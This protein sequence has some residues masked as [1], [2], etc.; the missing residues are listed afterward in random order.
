[1]KRI[2]L[3]IT[4]LFA[5]FIFAYAENNEV[6][7]IGT[8]NLRM[9]TPSDGDDSWSH[10]KEMVKDLLRFVDYDLL[11]TQEGFSHQLNDILQ[12]GIYKYIGA[13]RDDGKDAGEHSAIFYRADRFNVLEQGNFWLSETPDKPGLGWDATC[14]NRICSWGKFEDVKSGRQF[15]F[16]NVHFD[17]EGVVARRESSHLMMKRIKSIAGDMPVFLTGDF[18]AFPTDEP[19]QILDKSGFLKDA[20]KI[21]KELPFGPVCTYH[22]YDS[23]VKTDERI[24]YVWVTGNIAID[25]YGVLTNTLYGR[26]PSDHFP[27]LVVAEF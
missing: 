4:L 21:T 2:F 10:R 3:A 11:G 20:Y 23:T 25:K 15:Y 27:V 26:T 6:L 12:L 24:D 17:H 18:N 19:I 8:F 7:K 1:M 13:G 9:D 5:A 22:G 16:F 14:C